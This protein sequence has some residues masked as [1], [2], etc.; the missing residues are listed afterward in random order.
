M[1]DP[2]EWLYGSCLMSAS[3]SVMSF[4]KLTKKSWAIFCAVLLVALVTLTREWMHMPDGRLHFYAL[5][6]GQGDSLLIVTPSGR[7][8]LMDAGPDLTALQKLSEVLPLLRRRIDLIVLS[9][10][11]QDHLGAFPDLLERYE[12]GAAMLSGIQYPN[13]DYQRML[14]LLKEHHVR[15]IIPDPSKDIDLGDGVVLDV[16]YPKPGLFGKKGSEDDVNNT[17]VALRVL[18]EDQSILLAGDMEIPEE[19]GILQTGADVSATV[20][21]VAHHGSRTSSSTGWLIEAG[22]HPFGPAEPHEAPLMLK[23]AV[24][25]AGRN[26]KFKHPNTDVVERLKQFGLETHLTA[27]EGTIH[28]SW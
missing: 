16:L 18:Y 27:K 7:T 5:D 2:I 19:D 12:V 4:P 15:V 11:H 10:P 20:L 8:V 26:N 9:H 17:S 6:I 24:I 21:K 23:T 3:L 13:A 25:S 1:D 28:L 22:A 14:R